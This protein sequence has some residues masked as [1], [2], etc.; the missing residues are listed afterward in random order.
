[1]SIVE[2][3]TKVSRRKQR[4]KG[5]PGD[6][7]C[8]TKAK[9]PRNRNLVPTEEDVLWAKVTP[10]KSSTHLCAACQKDSLKPI[11]YQHSGGHPH[12]GC[13]RTC[14]CSGN[15]NH[16][17]LFCDLGHRPV[18]SPHCYLHMDCWLEENMHRVKSQ[19]EMYNYPRHRKPL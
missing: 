12:P 2:K 8:E 5:V 16:H 7:R 3:E 13:S 4:R 9:V 19:L 6:P 11:S 15:P 17:Y 1:M 14:T 18:H 10:S